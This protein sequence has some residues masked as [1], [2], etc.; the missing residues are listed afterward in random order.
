[1][2]M[3]WT[4]KTGLA[5]ATAF[6]ATLLLVSIGL[7]GASFGTKALLYRGGRATPA[8]WQNALDWALI[9]FAYIEAIGI[10]VGLLG[11]AAVLIALVVRGFARLFD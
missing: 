2:K 3:P 8:G 10:V 7:C 4:N 1:M 5:K 6:F 9:G 11:L